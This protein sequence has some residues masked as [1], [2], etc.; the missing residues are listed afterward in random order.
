MQTRQPLTS[1]FETNTCTRYLLAVSLSSS[2]PSVLT[3]RLK[4][5]P[6]QSRPQAGGQEKSHAAD[7]AKLSIWGGP[8]VLLCCFARA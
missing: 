5:K 8:H 6:R 3:D 2:P 1:S 4:C 7:E